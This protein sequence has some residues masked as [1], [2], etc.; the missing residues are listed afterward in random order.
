M[1]DRI[2]FEGS[3]MKICFFALAIFFSIA[4]L[5]SDSG[6]QDVAVEMGKRAIATVV[7]NGNSRAGRYACSGKNYACSGPGKG[8]LGLA[9]LKSIRT[10]R[11]AVALVEIAAFNLDGDLSGE[12]ACAIVTGGPQLRKLLNMSSAKRNREKCVE[13]FGKL[14]RSSPLYKELD[15]NL[16]CRTESEISADYSRYK[17]MT[18]LDCD[19]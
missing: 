7:M 9:L 1:E 10:E 3:A 4:A 15:P 5:A 17:K 6:R 12:Y 13:F 14:T 8:E 16:L 2:F 11:S 18:A 19:E